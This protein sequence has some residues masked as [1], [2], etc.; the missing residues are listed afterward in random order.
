MIDLA[1]NRIEFLDPFFRFL[2]YFDTPYFYFVLIPVIWL[3]FS[4]R[5]GLRIFYWFTVNN[6]F[7]ASMKNLIAW[8]RP[9]TE[10]PEIGFFHFK[11]Y[12]FPSGGAQSAMLLGGLLIYYWR[13]PAAWII[14]T[15]YIFLIGFSRLYIGVHYPLDVLGGWFFGFLI[16]CLF[17]LLQERI[18][19][20]LA[21]KG[22]RFCLLLS[23]A[24]PLAI[25][26][27][28]PHAQYSM[29][30]A[31]GVG[32]GTYFSLKHRLFLA[33][34]KNLMEGIGRSFIGI[35]TLFVFVFLIPGK[36]SFLQS[37]IAGLYMSLAASPVCRWFMLRKT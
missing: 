31:A 16:L 6:L 35:A 20:W 7:I 2:N 13:T 12:G 11:S 22:L 10:M 33:K 34:P 8:P 4:Y 1:K 3:G 21:K 36:G 30:S 9:S 24:I 18:E 23:L 25:V 32:L 29:G 15:I 17:I 26:I 5:W 14:G 37:F 27:L 28:F 19:E